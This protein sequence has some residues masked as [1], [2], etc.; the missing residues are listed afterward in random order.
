MMSVDITRC[1]SARAIGRHL[2]LWNFCSLS[3]LNERIERLTLEKPT[4]TPPFRELRTMP[5]YDQWLHYSSASMMV[6]T[7]LVTSGSD[8]SGV[9]IGVRSGHQIG[10][11]GGP[12]RFAFRTISVRPVGAGRG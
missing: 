3:G 7:R 11:Q 8:G 5:V 6:I 2:C 4:P 10:I 9:S 1:F 12:P